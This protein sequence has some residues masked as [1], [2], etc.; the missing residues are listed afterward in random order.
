M[1][2]DLHSHSCQS[3]GVLAPA[4]VAARA[5]ANGVDW[6]A[7][8]DHD[9]TSGLAQAA[10]AAG[11]LGMGF[12]PGIEISATFCQKTVHIVGLGIQA[13]HPALQAGLADIRRSR[14]A[15]AHQ[16]DA[17]LADCG[18]EHAYAGAL[19]YVDNPDLI[20]RVHFARH[21]LQ[22]GHVKSLQQAFDRYLGE[23][24]RAFVPTRW[25]LL[26]DAVAWI[27]AAGGK[28]VIAH[29]GR[30]KYTPQQHDALFSAFKDLGGQ[31]IEVVTGSH[32]PA[33]YQRYA[34]LA[35]QYGFQASRGSDF[36]APG[37]GRVDLG[38]MP[39]LPDGLTPVWADWIQESP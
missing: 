25:A 21:L 31:A 16:L 2:I 34:R 17:L 13:D 36:H 11:Q 39:P 22:A 1:N 3:D 28:A 30:Y 29:P 26:E 9:E 12:I 35:R 20:S 14:F 4:E 33:Q 27:L 38:A 10:Q 7:L 32:T 8:T 18:I 6:W 23:G 24:K 19:Q 15:R 37:T 5:R